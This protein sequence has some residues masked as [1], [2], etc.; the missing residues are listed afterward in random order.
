MSIYR[1][2]KNC[3]LCGRDRLEL[4][5]KITPTPPAN[6]FVSEKELDL[7]QKC[8]P[9]DLFQCVHCGHVQLL[10]VL[11]PRKLFENYVYVSGTSPVFVRHFD[12]Y[13]EDII[14]GF[15]IPSGSFVLDVG[16]N[17]GTM[18][19]AF[20][21]KG[22]RVLG[23]DPATGIAQQTT[24]SGIETLPMFF[25]D[26][27]AEQIRCERGPMAVIT[28]NNVFAHADDL[29]GFT[30]GIRKLLK[31]DGIFV[32]EVSYLVDVFEKTLFDTIYHE[33]LSYH[34]IGPLTQFFS[35]Q[36]LELFDAARV[37]TH[38]GSIRVFVQHDGGFRKTTPSV[39]ELVML[40]QRLGLDEPETFKLFGS[41]IDKLGRELHELLQDLKKRG[42]RIVGYGAPAKATTLM[43]H[44]NI[45]SKLIDYIV[46]DNPIK[47]DLYTPG[48]HIPV[49]PSSSLGEETPDFI[50]I[51]AWNFAEPIME[52]LQDFSEN[53]GKF[54]IPIPEIKIQ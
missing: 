23:I 14:S 29:T 25:T 24:E 26:E 39:S 19:R 5:L 27:L 1:T 44:F 22:M 36:G 15:E 42:K 31:D 20:Q 28:A 10:D 49:L 43:Y 52:N 54:I 6:A 30:K 32:F 4:V 2:R 48:L 33:H 38:G 3:R 17:D 53:G 41:K 50:L 37:N 13:A 40:E 51:L 35:E 45:N 46:D 47:Q 18:L 21:K 16:S 12:H 34:T 11:D 7:S 9:L 8:Y